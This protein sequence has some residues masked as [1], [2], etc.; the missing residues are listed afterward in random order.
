MSI[1]R[2]LH[3][4]LHLLLPLSLQACQKNETNAAE[5]LAE[6]SLAKQTIKYYNVKAG[7]T[8][9]N[10]SVRYGC[11]Y[12]DIA[13]WNHIKPPYAIAIGQQIKL[14]K[15][16]SSASIIQNKA[17]PTLLKSAAIPTTTLTQKSSPP[18]LRQNFNFVPYTIKKGDT[19]FSI[20]RHFKVDRHLIAAANN[21]LALNKLNTGRKLKIPNTKQKHSEQ[22]LTYNQPPPIQNLR[23]NPQKTSIISNNNENMLKFYCHWP[24]NGK[25]LKTFSTTGHRGIEI[26]GY[27]GQKVKAVANGIV[28]AVNA[29][30][31]GYGKFVVIKHHNHYMTSYANNHRTLVKRGQIVKQ[32]QVIAE[33]GKIGYKAPLLKFEIRKAGKL[34]NPMYFLPKR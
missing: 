10:I 26:S 7:D 16:I 4:V 3:L 14:F 20:S 27:S 9:I 31:Y 17:A 8:L 33:L 15:T 22:E 5:T 28:V 23:F 6:S 18:R 21:L 32:G 25:I 29:S 11:S 34:I 1:S 2:K 24:I 30:I 13:R 12:Q 19:L